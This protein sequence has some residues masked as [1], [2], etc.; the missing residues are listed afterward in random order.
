MG[1]PELSQAQ[2]SARPRLS[3]LDISAHQ[4]L[5][6]GTGRKLSASWEAIADSYEG[7]VVSKSVGAGVRP[8][9]ATLSPI[10]SVEGIGKGLKEALSTFHA[11]GRFRQQYSLR[12]LAEQLEPVLPEPNPV[13]FLMELGPKRQP[14]VLQDLP[15][16]PVTK[17]L[18]TRRVVHA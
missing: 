15:V 17:F 3:R 12:R 11:S 6:P 13:W 16:R 14:H 2:G 5:L 9:F 4:N 1:R 7:L 18:V 10:D 8:E